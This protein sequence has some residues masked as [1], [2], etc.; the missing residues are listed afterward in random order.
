MALLR[1]FADAVLIGAGTFRKAQGGFWY[2]ES[3][4]PKAAASFAELRA[5]LGSRPHPLLVVVTASGNIDTSQPALRDCLVITT[6]EGEAR[7]RG[8][9]PSETELAVLGSGRIDCH[10]L[11]EFLHARGILAIL[12]EGG[13]TLVGELLNENLINELFLTLSPHLFGRRSGDGRKSLVSGV[14]LGGRA[15]SL[16]SVRRRESYLYLRYRINEPK[17]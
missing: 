14:D 9:L 6:S 4:F 2:P 16:S 13:P 11:L 3:V 10:K 1:A 15:L 17:R 5:A 7:L 12:T 8:A